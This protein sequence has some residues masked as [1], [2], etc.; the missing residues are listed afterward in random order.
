MLKDSF[1]TKHPA[2]N[3]QKWFSVDYFDL[4]VWT[5]R[6]GALSGFQLCNDKYK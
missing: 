6:D 5:Y 2:S 3:T 1:S 4:I